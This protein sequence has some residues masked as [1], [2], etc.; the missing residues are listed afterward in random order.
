MAVRYEIHHSHPQARAIAL[1]G[2]VIRDDGVIIY[3]TDSCYALGC[4]L[5]SY[6]GRQRIKLIRGGSRAP[7]MTLMCADIAD[8]SSYARLENQA[9]RLIKS[10]TPGAYTFILRATRETPRRLQDARRKT[11]GVRI[12]DHPV[13]QALLEHLGSPILSATLR[14]PNNPEPL[15]DPIEIE[16]ACAKQVD[17][18]LD[19]GYGGSEPT[20]IVDLSGAT[21]VLRRRGRGPVDD[22]VDLNG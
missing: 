10:L 9:F 16:N 4:A 18:F 7:V 19:A 12:P 13:V 15:T 17:L 14:T 21:P 6:T 8:L 1:A 20:T 3:P 5:S 11:I 2:D 22:I